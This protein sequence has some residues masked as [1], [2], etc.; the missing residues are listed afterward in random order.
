MRWGGEG[1]TGRVNK[2]KETDKIE[3]KDRRKKRRE[4]KREKRRS[5]AGIKKQQQILYF[6]F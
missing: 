5:I 1:G 4:E 3:D 6:S 2:R